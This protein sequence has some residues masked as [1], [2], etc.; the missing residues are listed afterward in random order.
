MEAIYQNDKMTIKTP[1]SIEK[2]LDK[3][4]LQKMK[5][6]S[7]LSPLKYTPSYQGDQVS[8]LILYGNRSIVSSKPNNIDN[9]NKPYNLN[10]Y[11]GNV[12]HQ[13]LNN[14]NYIDKLWN[15]NKEKE[16][17][18]AN[19]QNLKRTNEKKY[20]NPINDERVENIKEYD[21]YLK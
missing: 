7:Y 8:R 10:G 3:I 19:Y 17:F 16:D 5:G 4:I 6:E 9:I 2:N 11:F 13:Y 15:L 18:D 12:Q 14:K 1:L 21:Y 20:F